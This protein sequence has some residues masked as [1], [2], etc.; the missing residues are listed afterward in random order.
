MS[1]LDFAAA[2]PFLATALV[3]AIGRAAAGCV[4]AAVEPL[5]SWRKPNDCP[6]C[7]GTGRG[8]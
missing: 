1:A 3:L 2:H 8:S 7:N 6:R 4:A 5:K